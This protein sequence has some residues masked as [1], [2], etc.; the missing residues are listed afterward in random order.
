MKSAYEM[1]I[2][3]SSQKVLIWW[4]L[5]FSMIFGFSL[6]FLIQMVPPPPPA[7][8][9]EL[10]AAYYLEHTATIRLGSAIAAW[11]AGFMVPLAVVIS[12]Q[13]ARLEKG[14]PIWAVCQFAGGIMTS[15]FLVLPPEFWGA[16]AFHPDRLADAT[17]L[18]NDLANLTLV[19]T[20]QYYMFQFVPIIVIALSTTARLGTPFPRWFGYYTILT[21]LIFEV[22]PLGFLF[23]SGP[24]TWRGFFVFWLPL[25]AFGIW[26]LI[27]A[28]LLLR[29]VSLQK[30][31]LASP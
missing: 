21:G 16:A 3:V 13:I 30:A 19:T 31:T 14:F 28:S 11:T 15:L 4:A 5:A 25:A 18:M 8:T 12:A 9:P 1:G 2:S 24:F 27:I 29:T 22:G 26:I 23:E 17:S 6:I 10:V 7:W 20:D